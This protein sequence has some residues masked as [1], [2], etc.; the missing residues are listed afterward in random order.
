M[1]LGIPVVGSTTVTLCQLERHLVL[2]LA[3]LFLW[4]PVVVVV[5]Q[6]QDVPCSDMW[7]ESVGV[8]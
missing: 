1:A 7:G 2:T 6:I 8:Q 5:C 4:I 3:V